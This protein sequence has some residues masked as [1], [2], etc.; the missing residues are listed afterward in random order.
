MYTY[1][2]RTVP[3]PTMMA[4]NAAAREICTVRTNLTTTPLQALTMMNNKTYVEA[5][6]FLA[7]RMMK[8][9]GMQPRQRVAEAFRAVTSRAPRKGELDLLMEDF[10]FYLKDFQANPAAAQ[11]LLTVGE[12]PRN[13]KL[14]AVELAAYALVANTL[15]NLD[16]A[17]MQN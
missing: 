8:A 16:E 4:F 5:A 7:E 17:I 12:K 1:W 2:R 10:A 11:K 15:L 14:N 6:R 9:D 3:P 13:A